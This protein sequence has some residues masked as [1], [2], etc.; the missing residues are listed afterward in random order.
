MPRFGDIFDSHGLLKLEYGGRESAGVPVAE[1][2]AFLMLCSV[3]L[4][5]MRSALHGYGTSEA[6]D[7]S[8]YT[9]E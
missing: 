8:S 5:C 7:K 3:Q 4:Q 2:W 9:R 1:V 6:S